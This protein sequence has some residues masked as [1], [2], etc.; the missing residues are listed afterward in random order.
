MLCGVYCAIISWFIP[1]LS[2]SYGF[3]LVHKICERVVSFQFYRSNVLF[4]VQTN[5]GKKKNICEAIYRLST[6]I[7][8]KLRALL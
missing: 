3:G 1:T 6:G 4:L 2:G 8:Y 5:V 7:S